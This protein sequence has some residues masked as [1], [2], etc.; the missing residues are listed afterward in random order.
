MSTTTTKTADCTETP[1]DPSPKTGEATKETAREV[2]PSDDSEYEVD[3]GDRVSCLRL[4][5]AA[6]GIGRFQ[7]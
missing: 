6:D 5:A 2:I 3:E 7:T 4:F 1:V